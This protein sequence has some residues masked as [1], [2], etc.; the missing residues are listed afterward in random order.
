MLA[1]FNVFLI[2]NKPYKK[3]RANDVF[4]PTVFLFPFFKMDQVIFFE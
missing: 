2:V 3:A 4:Q 1:L